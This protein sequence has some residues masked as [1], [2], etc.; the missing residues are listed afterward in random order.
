[1]NNRWKL[2]NAKNALNKVP[3]NNTGAWVASHSYLESQVRELRD[4]VS[5]LLEYVEAH[6]VLK[7]SDRMEESDG[8]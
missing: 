5:H 7:V 6:S 3:G 4:A 8:T 2:D 1:M